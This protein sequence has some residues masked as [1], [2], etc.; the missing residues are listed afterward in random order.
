MP[1]K[2]WGLCAASVRAADSGAVCSQ[3]GAP[4][5]SQE[6]KTSDLQPAWRGLYF[7]GL[8]P[9]AADRINM[10]TTEGWEDRKAHSDHQSPN[11]G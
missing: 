10:P 4:G 1:G 3:T 5:V 6:G 2:V 9:A 11:T 8:A 7:R